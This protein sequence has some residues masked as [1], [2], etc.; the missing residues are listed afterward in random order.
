MDPRRLAPY[1]AGL[2]VL[3]FTLGSL[4][5]SQAGGSILFR[6]TWLLYLIYLAPI[7]IVGITIALIVLVAMNWRDITGAVGFQMARQRKMRKRGSRWSMLLAGMFWALAIGVLMFKKGSIFNPEAVTNSTLAQV[8]TTPS[9]TV[10]QLAGIIPSISNLI[11]NRWFGLAFLGLVV[12]GGLVL[13]ESIRVAVRET[14]EVN[15]QVIASNRLESLGAVNEA[16]RLVTTGSTDPRSRIVACY[17][18]L[19]LTAAK[20][21]ALVSPNLTAREL[22]HAIRST[23]A[24]QGRESTELTKL[25]EEARYSLHEIVEEDAQSAQRYLRSIAEELQVELQSEN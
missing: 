9:I 7:I 16:I 13:A 11:D 8:Q 4:P 5:R 6:S 12:L 20:L 10:I 18:H 22:E 24:L 3:A 15:L 23:F 25:F 14:K 17:Q 2:L 19:L 21:G 1:I